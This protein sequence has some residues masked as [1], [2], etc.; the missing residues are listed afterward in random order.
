MIF[1]SYKFMILQVNIVIISLVFG[2]SLLTNT[3]ESLKLVES[4]SGNNLKWEATYLIN[5]NYSLE[6]IACTEENKCFVNSIS[7]DL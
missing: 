4:I 3:K 2:K 6:S 1:G 5:S 7:R